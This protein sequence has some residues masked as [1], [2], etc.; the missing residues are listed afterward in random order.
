MKKNGEELK[1]VVGSARRTEELLVYAIKKDYYK[2]VSVT[3]AIGKTSFTCAVDERYFGRRVV[4]FFPKTIK[5]CAI[6]WCGKRGEETLK[7]LKIFE[8]FPPIALERIRGWRSCGIFNKINSP[9]NSQ[10]SSNHFPTCHPFLH[11][12]RVLRGASFT[13][14]IS[15]IFAEL[16]PVCATPGEF[17]TWL[18]RSY[19]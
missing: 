6:R 11:P 13:C 4:R 10:T 7:V 8:T 17:A 18:I 5:R 9:T 14:R 15:R 19:N 16:A 12:W 3:D 1:Q 2:C